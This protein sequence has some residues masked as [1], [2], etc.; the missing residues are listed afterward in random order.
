MKDKRILSLNDLDDA[1]DHESAWRRRELHLLRTDADQ[2][3]NAANRVAM[4][5]AVAL[6]YAHWEGWVKAI[7]RNYIDFVNAQRVPLRELAPSLRGAALKTQIN[8]LNISNKSR[9]HTEFAEF[10]SGSS[11]DQWREIDKKLF[12]TESNLSAT[13]FS[14]LVARIGFNGEGY[15]L[16]DKLIED[17]RDLRNKIAH[18]DYVGIKVERYREIHDSV[19]KIC[20]DLSDSVRTAAT[21]GYFRINS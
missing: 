18:G 20:I 9:I 14:D 15:E 8:E 19:I 13:L 7:C 17:L 16:Y 10:I 5:A 11:M 2:T 3:K 1:L 4:R 12:S 6:L 21:S